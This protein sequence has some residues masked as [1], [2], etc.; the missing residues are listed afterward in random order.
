[1]YNNSDIINVDLGLPPEVIKGHEQAKIR[2]CVVVKSFATMKLAIIVPCTSKE[3]KFYSY[4]SVKINKGEANLNTDS[5]VLCHQIRTVSFERI[6][7]TIGKLTNTDF[8]KIKST[9]ADT[10]ELNE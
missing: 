1:M 5:Y 10:L 6:K 8:C 7:N 4:T 9:I 3:P 2:P